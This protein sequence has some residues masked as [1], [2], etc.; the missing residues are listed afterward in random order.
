M[1]L[2]QAEHVASALRLAHP[3]LAIELVTVTT[4]GD[5]RQ[6]IPVWEMGGRGVF[7]REVQSAVLSGRAEIGRA[8]V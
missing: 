1:A 4:T 2:W 7:V 5:R 8:H 3:G 6:D